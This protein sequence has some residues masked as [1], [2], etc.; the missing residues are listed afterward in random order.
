[1]IALCVFDYA[2]GEYVIRSDHSMKR[3]GLFCNLIHKICNFIEL[4]GISVVFVDPVFYIRD[5]MFF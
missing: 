5:A 2:D 4:L 3:R 1:M